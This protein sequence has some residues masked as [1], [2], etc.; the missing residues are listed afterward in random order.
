M[1]YFFTTLFVS[2]FLTVEPIGLLVERDLALLASIDTPLLSLTY[3]FLTVFKVYG[4]YLALGLNGFV[5]LIAV[6]T[7]VRAFGVIYFFFYFSII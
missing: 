4:V 7:S 3:A 1:S 5:Y 6:L 2:L